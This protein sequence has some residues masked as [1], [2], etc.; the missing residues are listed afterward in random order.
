MRV[1]SALPHYQLYGSLFSNLYLQHDTLE[2]YLFFFLSIFDA[3]ATILF[4]APIHENQPRSSNAIGLFYSFCSSYLS[5]NSFF[6][7]I[8]FPLHL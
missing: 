5:N 6:Y 2:D 1:V 4:N 3:I 8:L 7:H